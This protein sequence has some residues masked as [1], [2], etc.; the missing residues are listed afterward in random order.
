MRIL[1]LLISLTCPCF[2]QHVEMIA[3]SQSPNGKYSLRLAYVSEEPTL[4]VTD[5]RSHVIGESPSFPVDSSPGEQHQLPEI[6]WSA[7]STSVALNS[8]QQHYTFLTVLHFSPKKQRFLDLTVP[9][10]VA[11]TGHRI[12][13]IDELTPRAFVAAQKWI[14]EK[15]VLVHASMMLRA[16]PGGQLS[17]EAT[18][19]IQDSAL[20]VSETKDISD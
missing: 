8:K 14:D 17:F 18:L 15:T 11:L 2:A 4:Q 9:D 5:S 7:N 20:I 6:L 16:P 13:S 3:H 19:K 10:L 12:K 1:L